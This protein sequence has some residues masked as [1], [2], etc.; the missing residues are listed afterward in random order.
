MKQGNCSRLTARKK[1]LTGKVVGGGDN[2]SVNQREIEII[3]SSTKNI[4]I[5][6][7]NLVELGFADKR[8]NPD[9]TGQINSSDLGWM[10]GW[11]GWSERSG[12]IIK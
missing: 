12:R 9:Y 4:P 7:L 5:R 8:V 1:R 11:W 10:C 3:P 6:I 2:K